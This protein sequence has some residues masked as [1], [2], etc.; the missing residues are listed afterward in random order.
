MDPGGGFPKPQWHALLSLLDATVP[1]ILVEGSPTTNDDC[2]RISQGEFDSH[3]HDIQRIMKHPPTKTEF[4]DY[5]AIRPSDN[6]VFVKVIEKTINTLPPGPKLQLYRAL[7]LMM[8]RLGSL[9]S[10]GYFTPFNRQSVTVREAILRSW[11]DSWLFIWPMFAR[12][13]VQLGTVTWGKTDPLF[14][15]ISSYVG[16]PDSEPGPA[17]DFNF[18]YFDDTP[19]PA[20]I[21]TDIVIV[22]SGFGG[23]VCAKVL[24]EAGHRVL[25]VDKGY[26]VPPSQLPI[27]PE[28]T[29]LLF[30]GESGNVSTVDGSFVVAAGSCWGG[31]GVINWAVTLQP[32]D[33][34][35]KEWAED[36]GLKYFSTSEFQDSV[37]RVCDFVGV[38]ETREVQHTHSNRILLEGSKKLGWSSRTCPTNTST[39]HKCGS[40]CA[41]GCRQSNKQGPAVGWLPAAA[42]AGARGIEGFEVTEILFEDKDGSKSAVGIVGEWTPRDKNGN[43]DNKSAVQK[44]QVRVKAK[45]VIVA[46]GTLNSPLILLRSGLKNPN[47]GKHLYLHPLNGMSVVFNEDIRGW[48]G[49]IISSL[50]TEFEDL[51]G[52][53]Y[54][55]RIEPMSSLPHTTVFQIP[56][57]SGLEFKLAALKHRQMNCFMSIIR[58]RDTGTIS[59][60]PDDGGPVVSYAP[61][62]FDRK[63]LITGLVGIAKL[64][65]IQGALELLPTVAG[66]PC[67]RSDLPVQDRSLDDADFV[68][69]LARLEAAS[70]N[71]SS[72]ILCSGHQMG[73]CRMSTSP[74][75]GVVNEDGKVWD[76]ENLY[77]ADA[78]V[79]PTSSGVNPMITI[80]AIADHIARGISK[81]M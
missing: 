56:W 12:T 65:Y 50:V 64:C 47:I 15:K 4:R 23:A 41:Y 27:D 16:R 11:K 71:P 8:T 38:D 60:S 39:G 5:L 1:P 32:P 78:S 79:F 43:F 26:Y 21:E 68:A 67:Y 24:A 59:L 36:R 66:L 73:S 54:G 58:D 33:W 69:W 49:E 13:F 19:K 3:Y 29:E 74:T 14:H 17:V 7:S 57:H 61:S 40:R 10:T 30:E 52:K 42:K 75:T 34:L 81:K 76:T 6:P 35:R 25:V 20:Q 62:A 55:P 37:D 77:V 22:G 2:F 18:V 46:G 51:D 70:L 28:N 44:K 63:S 72:A 45:K 31:G 80:M 9:I 53:Y 48:E